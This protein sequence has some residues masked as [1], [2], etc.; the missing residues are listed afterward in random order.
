MSKEVIKALLS[1]AIQVLGK[2]IPALG[3]L[4]GGPL[5]WLAGLAISYLSGLLYDLVER[6]ARFASIDAQVHKDLAGA[7]VAQAVLVAAQKNP[8][9]TEAERAKALEDFT[10]AVRSLGKFK[11]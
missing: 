4:L 10:S 2:L 11:L 6:L 3:G 7:K 1:L 9:T 5:G 8:N